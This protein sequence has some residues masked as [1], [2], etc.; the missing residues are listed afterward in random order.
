MQSSTPVRKAI[1]LAMVL[2]LL[3]DVPGGPS[4]I[5]HWSRSSFTSHAV[6]PR[7]NHDKQNKS[8]AG[9]AYA[10]LPLRF[11]ANVGQTD[12]RVKFL[13]RGRGYNLFLTPAEAVLT[14]RNKKTAKTGENP[15]SV[16][17]MKLIGAN[18]APRVDG[19]DTL[20]GKSNYLIGNTSSKWRRNV[21]GFGKIRYRSVY[22]GIDLI[23][24]GNGGQQ[25]E[26]DF[27]VAAGADPRAIKFVFAGAKKIRMDQQGDLLLETSGGEVR[28]H[29]PAVYQEL[30]GNRQKIDSQY[31]LAENGEVS[32]KIAAYDRARPLVI[33]PVLSYATFLGRSDT[34]VAES[35]DVDAEGNAYITG[36]TESLDFPTANAFQPESAGGQEIF[37]TKLNRD[38]SAL[39]FS[40]FLGGDEDDEGK[41]IAIDQDGNIWLTGWTGSA[42]FP[43]KNPL[44]PYAGSVDGFIVKLKGDG[45]TLSFSTFLGGS[46]LEQFSS[47]KVDDSGDIYVTGATASTD[48]P[49]ANPVQPA[50]GGSN[51]AFVAKIKG[52]GSALIFSTYLGGSSFDFGTSLAVDEAGNIYVAGETNSTNFPTKNPLQAATAGRG[53]AFVTK[54]DAS[55][56]TL[57][58]STYL[59]GTNND[60]LDAIGIDAAGNIYL[61]GRTFSIDFPMSNP[62][63][64][65]LSGF[66]DIF[67][68]K[69]NQTGSTLLYST[70]LGGTDWEDGT[71][72]KIDAQ[73]NAYIT[74]GTL[75][76]DFPTVDAAQPIPDARAEFPNAHNNGFVTKINPDGSRLIYSSYLGGKSVDSGMGIALDLLGNAYVAGIT[77]S[78]DLPVTPGAFQME[79]PPAISVFD[80][81]EIFIIKIGDR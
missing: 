58:Y 60:T 6:Q 52:D 13:S 10:N 3:P 65:T 68:A 32:F 49:T 1:L 28:Q 30:N 40:T 50:N 19:E 36:F 18:P 69:L 74:G 45:S 76:I 4:Y 9:T 38:G 14:L 61:M 15:R 54:L 44:R 73:G 21:S 7:N 27:V 5:P 2:I 46:S 39:I 47:L 63:Q 64:P 75:S 53:D 17:R 33:D 48:F 55:G 8:R 57:L 71:D 70:Y 24:Y 59:G 41:D 66:K 11:E 20:P 62:L 23:Y 12:S 81:G 72:M 37:V 26:Y 31:V 35:I 67:V 22:P 43:T 29:K 56:Q 25:L 42:N 51:D 80:E 77:R 16:L 34:E 78:E 79:F